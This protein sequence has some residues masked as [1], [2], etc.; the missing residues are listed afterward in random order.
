MANA[1]EVEKKAGES[2]VTR[3]DSRKRIIVFTGRQRSGDC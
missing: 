2:I 3:V 1:R